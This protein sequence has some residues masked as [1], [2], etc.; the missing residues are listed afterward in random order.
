MFS[1][2]LLIHILLCVGIIALVLLQQGKGADMGAAFGAGSS[3]T[4][5]GSRGPASFLFKLTALFILLFFI[6]SIGLTYFQSQAAK[7]ANELILPA[8]TSI[9]VSAPV[10]LPF[11]PPL[12]TNS[13][14]AI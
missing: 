12:S 8:T 2:V 1:V 3:N 9:P 5:F 14:S 6:T 4:V 10:Q 11:T 13:P 7:K